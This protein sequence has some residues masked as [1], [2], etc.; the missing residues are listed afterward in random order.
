MLHAYI[1]LVA[2]R[3]STLRSRRASTKRISHRCR[4]C[5]KSGKPR[6]RRWTGKE[7]S[8][9][10]TKTGAHRPLTAISVAF[11]RAEGRPAGTV[12]EC[13]VIHATP[14]GILFLGET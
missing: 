14:V 8:D 2:S 3:N 9:Y 7:F 11:R 12:S 5:S 6:P 1:P 4:C 13:A 10:E